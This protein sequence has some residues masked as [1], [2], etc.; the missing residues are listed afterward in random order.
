M[1][2]CERFSLQGLVSEKQLWKTGLAYQNQKQCA[3]QFDNRRETVKD[4]VWFWRRP[5]QTSTLPAL[6]KAVRWQLIT[7]GCPLKRSARSVTKSEMRWFGW[8]SRFLFLQRFDLDTI[9]WQNTSVNS[10]ALWC[11]NQETGLTPAHVNIN[12][13]HNDQLQRQ[14]CIFITLLESD[15]ANLIIYVNKDGGCREFKWIFNK[16]SKAG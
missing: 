1:Q 4:S 12:L 13:Y 7:F 14:L 6:P 8:Q 11:I 2:V 3:I 16:S 10:F 15:F 9:S 5:L